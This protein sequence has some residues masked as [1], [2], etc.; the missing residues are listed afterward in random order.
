MG[1]LE[2]RMD[3][4]TVTPR[5]DTAR[6]L[7]LAA[8]FFGGLALAAAAAGVFAK[9]AGTE[10]A[11]LIA[12]A[13]LFAGATW[14]LDDAVRAYLRARFRKAPGASPGASPAAPSAPRTS[15]AGWAAPRAPAGD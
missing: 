9:L 3:V 2:H 6:V 10:L 4:K 14:A 13:A 15:A 8:A 7:L 1:P 5:E 12:F 11:A